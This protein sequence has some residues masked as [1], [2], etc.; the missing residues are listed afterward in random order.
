MKTVVGMFDTFPHAQT[1]ADALEMM[2]IERSNISVVANNETG[3]YD[4]YATAGTTSDASLDT[5]HAAGAGATAGTVVGGV[6]GLL[7]GLGLFVIPGFGPIAAAGWLVSTLTGAGIGAVAGGLVGALT[8]AGV[9]HEDAMV[10][11]EGVR[12]GATLLAVKAEDN[13]ADQVAEILGEH[14]AVDIDER[15]GQY[16]QEGFTP[17]PVS[18]VQTTPAA[19]EVRRTDAE[20][21]SPGA[22]HVRGGETVETRPGE[23]TIERSVERR[24]L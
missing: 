17:A 2:G 13:Q 21:E 23:S 14:G 10:F 9:P 11:N 5:A 15:G 6:T 22:Q 16:R 12:R 19:Q 8:H 7:M 18:E 24:N 1:A 4:Q 3:H 20:A